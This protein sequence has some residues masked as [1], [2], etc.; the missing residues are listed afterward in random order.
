MTLYTYE[1]PLET[2]LPIWDRFLVSGWKAS[3][4]LVLVSL[5]ERF[6]TERTIIGVIVKNSE[7]SFN[8]GQSI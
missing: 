3:L 2:V 1:L 5:C 4:L 8:M 7:T 6:E